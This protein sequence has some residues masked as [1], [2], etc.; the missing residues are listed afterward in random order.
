MYCFILICSHLIW[1]P[2]L[3]ATIELPK[4][5]VTL[6]EHYRHVSSLVFSK[7]SKWLVSGGADALLVLWDVTKHEKQWVISDCP[8]AVT[9]LAFTENAKTVIA[10]CGRGLGG[11]LLYIDT[12]SGKVR[13]VIKCHDGFINSIAISPDGTLLTSGGDDGLILIRSLESGKELVVLKG[14]KRSVKVVRFQTNSKLVSGGGDGTV[15][16]WDVTKKVEVSCLTRPGSVE[17]VCLLQG[18]ASIGIGRW[19]GGRD[20]GEVSVWLPS[21]DKLCI[22]TPEHSGAVRCIT[23]TSDGKYLLSVSNDRLWKKGS[24]VLIW[25]SRK[26]SAVAR[27]SLATPGIVT[28]C[29]SPDGKYLATGGWEPA[30]HVWKLSDFSL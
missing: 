12:Q 8:G 9:A 1:S 29:T 10:G 16:I 25:D 19:Y 17:S 13:K 7:D 3:P 30:I 18:T 20:V 21:K 24:K 5:S 22:L 28:M 23:S 27:V 4:P 2:G 11:Q 15:R 6:K 26:L 14:H